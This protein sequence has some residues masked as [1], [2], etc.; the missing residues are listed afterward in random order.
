MV[1]ALIAFNTG[2][3]TKKAAVKHINSK[4]TVQNAGKQLNGSGVSEKS[5]DP[6]NIDSQDKNQN[7]T[8]DETKDEESAATTASNDNQIIGWGLGLNEEHKTPNIPNTWQTMLDK[9]N[10]MFIGD[11]TKK[12]LY[13]TFDEGYEAGNTGKILDTLKSNN[14]KAA[15]FVTGH[16]V[17]TDPDLVKRMVKEG[18][19]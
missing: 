12:N 7:K 2:C 10:G 19:S 6:E 14:V 11:T 15:F 9:Y 1:F 17:D 18:L 4:K 3:T 13:L 5:A 16:F 8:D